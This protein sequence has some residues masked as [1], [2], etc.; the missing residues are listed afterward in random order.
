MRSERDSQHGASAL[1]IIIVLAILGVGAYIGIQ[2]VPQ[3]M[4]SGTLD[5]IFDNIA[6][7]NEETA[8][9][10]IAAVED[11]IRRQLEIN[12]MEGLIDDVVVEDKGDAFAITLDYERALDLLY[13]TRSLQYEKSLTL[14]K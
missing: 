14:P 2:Y 4:E 13:E 7:R 11:A 10:S 1:V 8:F 6:A 9:E 3:A 12:Q 5:S